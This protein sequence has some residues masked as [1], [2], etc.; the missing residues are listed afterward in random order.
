MKKIFNKKVISL[1]LVL[2][3]IIAMSNMVFAATNTTLNATVQFTKEH[4]NI[5]T[6]Q[7]VS[8]PM[9]TTVSQKTYFT[10]AQSSS[11]NINPLGNQT[12]IMDTILEAASNIPK[13]TVTG[14]DLNPSYGNPG[15]YI[16]KVGN[17]DTWN[18][19]W[20]ETVNGVVMCYS[21]GEGW[22]ATIT[23]ADGTVIP[24]MS[25]EYLS[26]MPLED[27]MKIVFDY[28]NYYYT[29]PK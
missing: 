9:G 5:W 16:S 3:M 28:S 7:P 8:T 10:Q 26:R 19:Y 4:Q 23:K 18:Q 29:W 27:G 25:M 13:S 20:E 15:A 22:T 17:L 1:A 2:M 24:E 21:T 12:S 11:T 6:T 14:V